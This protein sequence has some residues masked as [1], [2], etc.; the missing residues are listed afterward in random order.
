[1]ADGDKDI[2]QLHFGIDIR[3]VETK[4]K[5]INTALG[6]IV[7][8]YTEVEGQIREKMKDLFKTGANAASDDAV[9]Q[10]TTQ[11]NKMGKELNTFRV[12]RSR[13]LRTL[14]DEL[15]SS[16]QN[17]TDTTASLKS[18][19]ELFKDAGFSKEFT[20]GFRGLVDSQGVFKQFSQGLD[21]FRIALD[22]PKG[23][24]VGLD[25]IANSVSEAVN[26]II[27]NWDNLKSAMS[28]KRGGVELAELG[29]DAFKDHTAN[30]RKRRKRR[31]AS[32]V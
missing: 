22:N 4:V 24:A 19:L 2:L 21:N 5:G 29:L 6:S 11:L 9:T 7:E 1:M 13:V 14:N 31:S 17:I 25:T 32:F 30:R 26:R 10:Y 15:A 18:L 23:V 20:N 3:D 28:G 27:G 8:K 16:K 12:E